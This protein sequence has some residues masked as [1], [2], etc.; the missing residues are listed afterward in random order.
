M[1]R[2][3]FAVQ[4]ALLAIFTF[5]GTLAQAQYRTSI[6]GVVTDATGA[7]IPGANLTLI[8]RATNEK[9]VRVSDA[10]GVF[11]FNALGATRFRLEVNAKGFEKRVIDNL[12]LIPEQPNGLKVELVVGAEEQTITVNA[13]AAPLLDT[14]TASVNGVVSSNQI[15]HMP[16]FGRDVL[17]LA[18]LAPGVFGDGS[19]GAGGGGFKLRGATRASSTQKTV[20][21]SAP[22]VVRARAMAS[23][24]T[25][26]VR[27]APS[28]VELQSSL[29]RKIPLR[30]LRLFLTITTRRMAASAAP[31]SRSPPRAA[32]TISTVVFS[33]PLTVRA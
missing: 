21:R 18:Q 19:Q 9:Q 16:S 29:R 14:E 10:N 25:E 20:H 1:R 6:Q 11:N 27:P 22:M 28:G 8:N 26:S 12:E 2:P 30:A 5:L 4:V 3:S 23:P 15:Q 24:L 32:P 17:K 13:D 33:L 7:V 31:R